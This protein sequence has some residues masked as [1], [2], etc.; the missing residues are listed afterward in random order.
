MDPESLAPLGQGPGAATHQ[1]ND[2]I[3]A[4]PVDLDEF[5]HFLDHL[6]VAVII[7]KMVKAEPRI[8]IGHFLTYS[9]MRMIPLSG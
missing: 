2:L 5:K 8:I 3:E 9:I 4:G 6:P 1:V 7:S